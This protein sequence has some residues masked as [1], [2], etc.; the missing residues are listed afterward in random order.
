MEKTQVIVVGAGPAGSTAAYLLAKAGLD[1]VLFE[2]GEHPGSKAMFGG[3]LYTTVLHELFPSF[4]EDGC[5]ERH[6]VERRFSL[7]S[8]NEE[9]ALTFRG[10]YEPPYYNHAFTALRSRF[11]GWLANKAQE[12]GAL[13]V[14]STVV[15]EVIWE[16]SHVAGVRAR[17]DDGELYADVVIAADGANSLLAQQAGL[18]G[19]LPETA[20]L[21]VKEVLSLPREVIEDRFG[22]EGDEG[23]A[24]EYIGGEATGGIMGAGFI[25]TNVDTLSVGVACPLHALKDLKRQPQELLA[26]FQQH[27][28][29]RRLLRGAT[30]EE[31]S[32]H[33]I[34]EIGPQDMPEP[35]TDGLVVVGGAA[36]LVNSN[37]LF[38]E[39]INLSMASGLLAAQTVVEAF[40]AGDFSRTTLGVYAD[41]LR[42]SFVMQD[43]ARYAGLTRFAA[44]HQRFFAHYPYVFG[45]MAR[46]LFSPHVI[47]G[48]TQLP[49]ADVERQVV[50]DFLA[51]VGAYS[52]LA[53]ILNMGRAML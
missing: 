7:L 50:D 9:L 22:L 52:F 49:K 45:D 40:E 41:R 10:Q 42:S 18:R 36:G 30:S 14:A 8:R 1:V 38:H 3:I 11:D 17:R 13:L 5:V 21:G 24:L 26:A 12:A 47:E 43:V 19:E 20:V 37:P 48:G 23:A 51:K 46:K 6:V 4:P 34:P 35:A 33:L 39:G 27:P 15:D 44:A 53:D 31:F 16:D 32:A 2:R 25:Y 28:S 29:V